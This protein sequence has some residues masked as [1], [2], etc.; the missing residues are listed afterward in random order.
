MPEV[1]TAAPSVTDIH[2][3][4]KGSVVGEPGD[5]NSHAVC[6]ICGPV[7][8]KWKFQG[9]GRSR[10]P[11]CR[12]A[13][14]GKRERR[15]WDGG[16]RPHGLTD[17]EARALRQ[18]KSCAICDSDGALVIDHCHQTLRIRGV[19]CVPCNA[20]LHWLENEP[21]LRAA[22]AYLSAPAGPAQ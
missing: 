19:L 17:R 3:I 14:N 5:P 7:Q 4:V 16:R 18:G 12:V 21:W 8:V 6:S 2:R 1:T 15:G 22:Q 9:V 13:F 20:A 11:R 10:S